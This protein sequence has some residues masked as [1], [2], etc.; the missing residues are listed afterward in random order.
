MAPTPAKNSKPIFK[1][2]SPFTETKWLEIPPN[3]QDIILDLVCN[4]IAPLGDHRRTHVHPSKGKKRKRKNKENQNGPFTG[5][6][7]QDQNAPE[8]DSP[9]APEIS[10]HILIGINSI[11]RH[12]EAFAAKTA[13]TSMPVTA[14][15]DQQHHDA[16]KDEQNQ[17]TTGK[18]GP[19]PLSILIL[20]HPKPSLSLAHA[21]LPTLLHLSTLR[22]PDSNPSSTSTPDTRTRLISLPTSS[23]ARL[24]SSLH[25]PR[26]GAL[27]IFANAPG[28]KALEEFVRDKV[29][30][31]ECVW[32]DEAM[33]AEWR[34]VNVG[35]E[36][37]SGKKGV[38][39]GK[40]GKKVGSGGADKGGDDSKKVK[41]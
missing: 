10:K 28:A 4:L 19:R 22:P 12:L 40:Q 27:A 17:T 41:G 37:G 35:I 23:D 1:T 39:V 11:T 9:P 7:K 14:L 16:S 13:P 6:N 26:V 32:V 25:I 2:S 15:K 5:P 29:G 31:T 38:K 3:D 18:A 8:T 30:V 20:T 34:G 24:A 21:H 36:I 33:R